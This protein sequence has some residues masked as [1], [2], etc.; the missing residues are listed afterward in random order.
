[1]PVLAQRP[2][3]MDDPF[4]RDE[5]A[6]RDFYDGIA[7]TGRFHYRPAGTITSG[8]TPMLSMV[9]GS[10]GMNVHEGAATTTQTGSIGLT[11]SLDYEL[12]QQLDVSAV[13]DAIGGTP[14]SSL[15]LSWVSIKRYWFA[16]GTDFALRLAFDPRPANTSTASLGLRQIDLA[17]MIH[18]GIRKN[19]SVDML[20]GVRQVRIG[21]ERLVSTGSI[22]PALAEVGEQQ[23]FHSDLTLTRAAGYELHLLVQTNVHFNKADSHIFAAALFEGGRYDLEEHLLS[24]LARGDTDLEKSE[25]AGHVLWLRS[26]VRWNRPSYQIAPFLSFPMALWK[27]GDDQLDGRG[28]VRTS[29]GVSLTLR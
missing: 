23:A 26:G 17:A 29:L 6:R 2:F 12:A 9:P 21:F 3:R 19:V 22:T 28:R 1:M 10:S 14:G 13:F 11:F 27:T 15:S 5:T 24:V 7:V 8:S 25:Y 4:Y 18:A 16:N 20:A